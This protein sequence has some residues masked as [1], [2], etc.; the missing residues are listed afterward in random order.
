MFNLTINVQFMIAYFIDNPIIKIKIIIIAIKLYKAINIHLGQGRIFCTF[1]TTSVA[2][3]SSK[4]VAK[5]NICLL[6][7]AT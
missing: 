7:T 4:Y 6:Q 3:N 2:A 1:T 5:G